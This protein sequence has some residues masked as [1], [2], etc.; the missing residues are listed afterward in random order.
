MRFRSHFFFLSKE[1]KNNQNYY[2]NYLSADVYFPFDELAGTH[3]SGEPLN[4]TAGAGIAL[5]PNAQIAMGNAAEV[6]Q[7]YELNSK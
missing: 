1:K 3:L 5:V 4:G 6:C 2:S 7:Q